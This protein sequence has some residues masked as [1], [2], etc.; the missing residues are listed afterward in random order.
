M[1]KEQKWENKYYRVSSMVPKHALSLSE[2]T[3][4]Q[5]PLVLLEL[6]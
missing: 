6:D 2:G 1:V 5:H 4:G 3:K